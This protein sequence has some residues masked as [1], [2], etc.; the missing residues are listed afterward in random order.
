MSDTSN[1][2]Q[3]DSD[4]Q[5]HL[6]KQERQRDL[7]VIRQILGQALVE[8]GQTDEESKSAMFDMQLDAEQERLEQLLAQLWDKDPIGMAVS[9]FG[10]PRPRKR[11]RTC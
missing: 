2:E 6:S 9:P 3:P 1:P 5:P 7:D 4:D 11:R 10:E 8:H